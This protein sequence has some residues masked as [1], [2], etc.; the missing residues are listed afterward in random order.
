MCSLRPSSSAAASSATPSAVPPPIAGGINN[1]NVSRS[2][3]SFVATTWYAGWHASILA[4]EDLAWDKYISA[5]YAFA[6]TTEDPTTVGNLDADNDALLR[7]FVTAAHQNNA[8][9][10]LTIGGWTGSEFFSIN[11]GSDANRTAFVQTMVNLV[12][13]YSLDGL[14]FDWEYP[15]KVGDDCNIVNPNDSANFLTFLQE[16]RATPEM[17][18]RTMSAAAAVVP[19][20]GTDGNPM[21]DVS[22]FAKTLDYVAIMNY[23]VWGTWSTSVGPN[24]PLN[25][26]CAGTPQVVGSAVSA[27][28]AWT[29]ANFPANQLVLGVASYGH[30]FNVTNAAAFATTTPAVANGTKAIAAYPAFQGPQPKGDSLDTFS[31]AGVDSCGNPTAAGY[32]GVFNFFGLIDSGF[33]D[34][35]GNPTEGMGYRFDE[36][37]QTPYVYN[38][39]TQEMVSYDNAQSFA[40]K[41]KFIS[42]NSLLG[43]AMWET[44]GDS[45]NILLD[46]ISQAMGIEKLVS[47]WA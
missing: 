47:A 7:R 27:L 44:A 37:S 11:V 26:S 3:Q 23:D 32:S 19:F 9:A 16:L 35:T 30:S 18:N 6:T 15:G 25:D 1:G 10:L 38:P 33:L 43:F 20:A 36:C 42:D 34:A 2:D 29:S 31:P 8:S 17:A 24:A 39:S 46:S 12:N 28:N 22:E 5:T 4:P 21:N 13:E 41:G 14:D 45:N 40:A